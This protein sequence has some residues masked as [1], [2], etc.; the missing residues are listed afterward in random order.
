MSISKLYVAFKRFLLKNNTGQVL[1]LLLAPFVVT[2]ADFIDINR[3][4]GMFVRVAGWF[5][6]LS[7]ALFLGLA[8]AGV[9]G[10]LLKAAVPNVPGLSGAEYADILSLYQILARVI[11]AVLAFVWVYLYAFTAPVRFK[12]LTLLFPKA[13]NDFQEPPI[14]YFLL[15]GSSK[16]VWGA[17]AVALGGLLITLARS[18]ENQVTAEQ[19]VAEHSGWI[20]ALFIVWG[21]MCLRRDQIRSEAQHQMFKTAKA[22]WLNILW[23]CGILVVLLFLMFGTLAVLVRF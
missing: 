4:K 22:K 12:V 10:M 14:K 20:F 8:G 3:N 17:L 19:F 9:Y 6:P 18:I 1:L 13:K 21:L 16:V 7:S 5:L 11:L 23:D 15:I 2:P